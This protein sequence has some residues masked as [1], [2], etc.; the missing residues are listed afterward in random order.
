MT[1]SDLKD[2][3]AQS[4]DADKAEDIES[5]DLRD[6]TA[7]ADYMIVASGRSTR[8][9][10]AMAEKLQERLAARGVRGLRVEGLAVGDWVV[11]DAG[12]VIVHLFRPEVREFY[13]IEKMWRPHTLEVVGHQI[14]A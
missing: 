9:V 10:I 7:I 8:Q 5:I 12:D 6:Q 11:L 4:L 1:P 2:L 13:N 3:I 14:F